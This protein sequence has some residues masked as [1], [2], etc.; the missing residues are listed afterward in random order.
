MAKLTGLSR[1]TTTQVVLELDRDGWLRVSGRMQG[2]EA[3]KTEH[4][5]EPRSHPRYSTTLSGVRE[6]RS[7]NVPCAGRVRSSVENLSL[8][9]LIKSIL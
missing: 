4:K 3:V 5:G 2:P 7:P 1:Q 9:G 8:T 6:C